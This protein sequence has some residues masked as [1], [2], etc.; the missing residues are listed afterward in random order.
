MT[1]QARAV[2]SHSRVA[3]A[4]ALCGIASDSPDLDEVVAA[5]LHACKDPIPSVRSASLHSLEKLARRTDERVAYLNSRSLLPLMYTFL[6]DDST[7]VRQAAA[8]ALG[9]AGSR[10]ELLLVEGILKD[11]NATVRAAAAFGLRVSGPRTVRTLLLAL[12]DVDARVRG[13]V[14]TTLETFGKKR[15]YEVRGEGA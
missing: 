5:L 6:R 15:L 1:I 8:A 3:A 11:A 10:G 7:D 9:R 12:N 2:R 13:V 4:A 14:A